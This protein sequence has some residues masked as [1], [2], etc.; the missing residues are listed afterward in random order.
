M[1][2]SDTAS[3][4][5]RSW[6]RVKNPGSYLFD[7]RLGVPQNGSG[8]VGEEKNPYPCR[9]SNSDCPVRG[10]VTVLLSVLRIK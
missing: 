5:G 8:R 2:V 1:E 7:R 3:R 10:S 6:P 4:L 9:E